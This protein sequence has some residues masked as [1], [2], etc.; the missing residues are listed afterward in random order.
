[1]KMVDVEYPFEVRPPVEGG[2]RRLWRLF[3]RFA[4]LL[5]GRRYARGSGCQWSRCTSRLVGGSAGI[6]RRA[7][8]AVL[9]IEWAVRAACSPL[10]SRTIDRTSKGR[11]RFAEHLGGVTG[12]AGNRARAV[13]QKGRRDFGYAIPSGQIQGFVQAKGCLGISFSAARRQTI[14]KSSGWRA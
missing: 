10:A 2:R 4:G 14:L 12:F 8:K 13:T 11:R 3:S 1:M 6:R 5:V 7:A 9:G